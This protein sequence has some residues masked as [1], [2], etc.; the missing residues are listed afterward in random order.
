MKQIDDSTL[1]SELD[2]DTP[3]L[4]SVA[5]AVSADD[6]I[7]AREALVAH[8]RTRSHPLPPLTPHIPR[9]Q[10][11]T[12]D[13][14]VARAADLIIDHVFELLGHPP[15]KIGAK[16]LWN[17]DPVDYDQWAISLNR[18]FFWFTLGEAYQTTGDDKYAREFVDQLLGWIDA[19]P[20]Q[21]GTRYFQGLDDREDLMSLSLDAGIRM[22]QTWV[23]A[24]Y[25]F[26][27]A[28]SFD[29]EAHISM[30]K[31]FRDHAHYLMDPAHYKKGTNWS[32]MESNGLFYIGA[33]FPEFR[34]SE[35]WRSTAIERLH[36]ELGYQVYPDGAQI[37]LTSDYH[38][39]SLDNFVMT[40]RTAWRNG[41][42]LPGD[43]K[44]LLE[45]MYNYNLYIAFPDLRMPAVNDGGQT[46]IRSS[47]KEGHEFFPERDDFL[48]AATGGKEGAAPAVESSA[49]PYAGHFV[50]RSG[51]NSDDPCLFF[52]GGP[53]GYA[54]QHEDKLNII[55]YSH[56]RVHI[57]D[58]GNYQ[59]DA[60]RWRAY[61]LGTR[62]H[63]TIVVDGLEQHRKGLPREEYICSEPEPYTWIT[64]SDLDY[65]TAAYDEGYGSERDRTVTHRRSILFLKPDIYIV[66]DFLLP[67][68]DASHTYESA[69]HLDT[70]SATVDGLS[71]QTNNA[72]GGNLAI[73]AI[74][75]RDASLQVILAQEEPFIQGWMPKGGDVTKCLPVPTPVYAFGGSGKLALIYAIVP[76]AP[77]EASPVSSLRA[78]SVQA[79]DLA[80]AAGVLTMVDGREFHF[81][82]REPG[83]ESMLVGD[84]ETDAESGALIVDR[85]GR[86][87]K[88]LLV[89]GS[90]V[91]GQG[92]LLSPGDN[93]S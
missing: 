16:I 5:A 78:I 4:E 85:S 46:D 7:S 81:A 24:Y 33:Y 2:L 11:G 70:E 42:D 20:V 80:C 12:M 63:N 69:F 23:P 41:F 22:G 17:E 49:F 58:P 82:Q 30:L 53:Y 86:I 72:E 87:E 44:T 36:F 93:I 43:Y 61:T 88:V 47:M 83:E 77:G 74:G 59:Y 91:W 62:S 1:F 6:L 92:A 67:A 3:G 37:E 64:N 32:I 71:V 89:N 55:V 65:V 15:Q 21:I 68:D 90:G 39:V 28:P 45:R 13:S 38:Q 25:H 56:G 50:M 8:L 26:L 60:S 79:G 75:P 9:D 48:W 52:D 35:E 40:M 19:M 54:H 14:D 34:A 29:V 18:H 31:A 66:T 73:Y 27:N 76:I 84:A 51:W 10:L 57:A